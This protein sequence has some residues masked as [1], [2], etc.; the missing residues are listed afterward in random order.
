[1]KS[2]RV[3]TV[4][5]KSYELCLIYTIDASNN[6]HA[7]ALFVSDDDPRVAV[8]ADK[9][10][11]K[12]LSSMV[13]SRVESATPSLGTIMESLRPENLTLTRNVRKIEIRLAANLDDFDNGYESYYHWDMRTASGLLGGL[14]VIPLDMPYTIFPRNAIHRMVSI[15][16][17]LGEE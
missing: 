10:A 5:A 8:D 14:G 17:F 16:P 15:T 4:E 9:Q 2:E 13:F 11:S 12:R 6:W 1:M 3:D 7:L